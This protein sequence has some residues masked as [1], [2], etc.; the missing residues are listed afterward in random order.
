MN[1][2][3]GSVT[4]DR[5]LGGR[6]S[7]C[8]PAAGY[9]AAIDPVLLAAAVPDAGGRLLDIGCGVGAATIC[10]AWRVPGSRLTGVE[11]QPDL[12]DLARRNVTTNRLSDRVEIIEGDLL[13]PPAGLL[14]RPF[15]GVMANPP[16]QTADQS[17]SPDVGKAVANREGPAGLAEWVAFAHR[18]LKPKG[19][20]VLIHRA[21]RI[22]VLCAL[23]HSRFGA[24]EIVPLWP[25]RG[26][27]ARRVIV[28]ARKGLKSPA[29]LA[30]GLVLHEGD[31]RF[32]PAAQAVLRDGAA[33]PL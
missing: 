31:G 25:K 22:D 9:R 27:P 21:D 23:L 6:L 13:D 12:V 18:V 24:I 10:V 15:D 17:P 33:L 1:D 2:P 14:D 29:V 20:L 30:S 3:A 8:Q 7:L 26:R 16:F 5:L 32:T 28:R 19:W 11:A 4:E